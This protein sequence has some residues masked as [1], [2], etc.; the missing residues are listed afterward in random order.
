MDMRWVTKPL[1]VCCFMIWLQ[2]FT[3]QYG[4]RL[5]ATFCSCPSS[6]IA[7]KSA[8]NGGLG[9]VSIVKLLLG[10]R[11]EVVYNGRSA[12]RDAILADSAACLRLL[13]LASKERFV[14]SDHSL[15][16]KNLAI[17]LHLCAKH[18]KPLCMREILKY[19]PDVNYQVELPPAELRE[20]KVVRNPSIVEMDAGAAAAP[21]LSILETAAINGSELCVHILLSH[22]DLDAQIVK[23][24]LQTYDPQSAPN[25]PKLTRA[26]QL[27]LEVF[28]NTRRPNSRA[29]FE[30]TPLHWEAYLGRTFE[31]RQRMTRQ[32]IVAKDRTGRMPLHL[33]AEKGHVQCV[34]DLIAGATFEIL[35][36]ADD[37]GLTPL[38]LSHSC[39]EAM[40]VLLR[41]GVNPLEPNML[42]YFVLKNDAQG[43]ALVLQA[44]IFASMTSSTRVVVYS[45]LKLA[46]KEKRMEAFVRLLSIALYDTA[47][48]QLLQNMPLFHLASESDEYYPLLNILLS[49]EALD[50]NF[51]PDSKKAHGSPLHVAI[52]NGALSCAKALCG[53]SRVDCT[54]IDGKGRSPR[55]LAFN[56]GNADMISL[57]GTPIHTKVKAVSASESPVVLASEP[58]RKQ[59]VRF[60]NL[61]KLHKNPVRRRSGM[62]TASAERQRN[63]KIEEMFYDENQ[64]HE[65]IIKILVLGAGESGKSTLLKQLHAIY[66]LQ[67]QPEADYRAAIRGNILTNMKALCTQLSSLRSILTESV[68][69]PED[70]HYVLGSLFPSD[71]VLTV[72]ARLWK[73][74]AIQEV[75]A[76]RDRYL[77]M[78]SAKYLFDRLDEIVYLSDLWV[79]NSQDCLRARIRTTGVSTFDAKFD[80]NRFQFYD[81]GG[82][83]NQREKWI[84]CFQHVTAIMYVASLSVYDQVLGEDE[85]VSRLDDDLNLWESICN[86]KWFTETN[87]I[88]LLNKCDIFR[89]KIYRVPLAACIPQFQS[90]QSSNG[91]ADPYSEGCAFME[92]LYRQ[93]YHA[94][95]ELYCHVTC[96]TNRDLIRHVFES[97]KDIVLRQN[98]RFAGLDFSTRLADISILF[99]ELQPTVLQAA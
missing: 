42:E 40:Q 77:L 39:P 13:L 88:L 84:H 32:H 76:Q 82:Q 67:D 60:G 34:R 54:L 75:Y 79:P 96:H 18:N 37:Q 73:D 69:H 17:L 52:Q 63:R 41:A 95:Q 27:A 19:A 7:S 72:I 22:P 90:W 94:K 71:D 85:S 66:G 14:S 89:E 24:V 45:T 33:A 49:K 30:R 12:A 20:E 97:V 38:M 65:E 61:I 87:I 9:D 11:A 50:P 10:G 3:Q 78:D 64:R 74:S 86:G 68:E 51:I 28:V 46:L 57:F 48:E 59:A 23:R 44:P 8:L 91:M 92:F 35:N 47:R 1:R 29:W 83:Q 62:S 2:G 15:D 80:H 99:T 55:D 53:S 43:L 21:K 16:A 5:D 36:I 25:M 81:V 70:V 93:R 4:W 98:F 6:Y 26:I 31:L 56:L 58:P